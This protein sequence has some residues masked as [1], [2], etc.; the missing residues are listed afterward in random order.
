MAPASVITTQLTTKVPILSA[1]VLMPIWRAT[2]SSAP[3]V[4]IAK[5]MRLR[6]RH[7]HSA[8]IGDAQGE[9]LVVDLR[10]A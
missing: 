8:M 6:S 3:S 10:R 5:P 1:V 7:S 9:Q 2:V 4:V